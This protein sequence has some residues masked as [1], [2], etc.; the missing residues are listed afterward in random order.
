MFRSRSRLAADW[1][2]KLRLNE[3]TNEVESTDVVAVAAEVTTVAADVTTVSAE[4][5]TVASTAVPSGTVAFFGMS[6]PPTGWIKANGA[7]ISRTTYASLFAAIG[8]T[9]GAGNGS[10]T[11][12]LPDLRGEFLRGWDDGRGA[13]SGRGFGSY[14]ADDNKSHS[15]SGTTSTNGNH[16]HKSVNGGDTRDDV[17]VRWYSDQGDWGSRY[18]SGMDFG[19]IYN[20]VTSYAGDHNHTFNTSASGS[21]ARPRNRALLACIKY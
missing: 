15:H 8:T 19:Y 3:S 9:Y 7:A 5:T 21:E 13:D 14:Q 17:A 4:I 12:N 20:A 6:T 1:F 16:R 2:A 11:F 18:A 10:T